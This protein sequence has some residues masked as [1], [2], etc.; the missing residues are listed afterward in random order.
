MGINFGKRSQNKTIEKE[1]HPC[2][3]Y[4]KLDRHASKGPLR[5]PVQETVLNQWFDSYRNNK[6]VILK[7]PTG[8]GKTI[9]GLLMLQSKLNDGQTPCL[10]L[11]PN[12]YL[13]DQVKS[14]AT[15]FG[16]PFCEIEGDELPESFI[17]GEKILITNSHMLFNGRSTKFGIGNKSIHVSSILLDDAHSCIEVIKSSCRFNIK[18]NE[19][20]AFEE[21]FSLFSD[22]LKSQGAG[23]FADITNEDYNAQLAIPYWDWLGKQD[24]VIQILS[25]Y[26]QLKD[27]GVWFTWELLKDNL[28]NCLCVF[29][30]KEI[31]ISPYLLPI[32]KFGSF[33]SAKHRIFMSA[34]MADDSFFI[35]DLGLEKS[36]VEAPLTFDKKWSGEKMMLIPSLIDES[37][38]REEIVNWFGSVQ[39]SQFGI[40]VLT[41][42]FGHSQIWKSCGSTIIT[43]ANLNQKIS[44][45][46]NSKFERPIVMA[47]R[48]D[49]TDLPDSM[50][51]ILILDSLPINETLTEKYIDEC[52]PNSTYSKVK[53]AQ[54]IE[55]GLG[56]A[57]RSEKDFCVILFLGKDLIK[58]VR[59]KDSREYFS[60]QTKKQIEIGLDLA[61]FAKEDR[62][63]GQDAKELLRSIINQCLTRDEGW[64]N[65]YSEQMNLISGN[66]SS[67]IKV[68]EIM[69]FEKK[70]EDLFHMGKTIEAANTIQSML[71]QFGSQFSVE[72]KG[73]YLQSIARYKYASDQVS[74][75]SLQVEAHKLNRALF[76]P[77]TGYE[78][79]KIALNAQDRVLNIKRRI[80]EFDKF[81]DL[82]VYVDDILGRL[83]FGV[84]ADKFERALDE[85]GILLGYKTERPD[86]CWKS[87]PDN[88]WALREG[89]YLFIECKN[90]VSDTR[91]YIEKH[92][93]GQFSSNHAWYK[94]YYNGVKTHYV[95][96][97]PTLRVNSNTG[98]NENVKII[99]K[100]KLR[101]LKSKFRT[102]ITGFKTVDLKN[103]SLEFITNS[104]SQHELTT[105]DIVS[106][107]VE[108]HQQ[109]R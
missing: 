96:I 97:I 102:F 99:R 1:V 25:K 105:D 80:S 82:L 26:N 104:L 65:Y 28:M 45:F 92:E 74:G 95:M 2:L 87:G 49:G 38:D 40:A 16:V 83:S 20:G 31:E 22:S 76:L 5:K 106:K 60:T 100:G 66:N 84:E 77:P 29:S 54:T 3:I 36:V 108:D 62:G 109:M 48:Y 64:K 23:T 70:A 88:L 34:T 56:R 7:L 71:D 14:Q 59:Y 47:S 24:E 79:S 69:K 13:V 33:F 21:L 44:E 93:T 39:N 9:V 57:V 6:D 107:Y 53:L 41:P 98:F 89:E 67:N 81:E 10:Y 46:K 91:A 8:E 12:N 63:S 72:E 37:L 101:E 51:R 18:K 68:D 35:R 55:Q 52:V 32:E 73:W 78:V 75:M 17:N 19:S 50:C 86:K 61:K 90:E 58:Q 85:L 42:S 43:K 4:E 103:I 15:E 94:R 27:N 11:C 30:G